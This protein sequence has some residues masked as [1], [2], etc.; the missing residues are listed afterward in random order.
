MDSYNLEIKKIDSEFVLVNYDK[1][2]F[3]AQGKIEVK[4]KSKSF[5]EY[6]LKDFER[7][8]EISVKEDNTIDFN[9]KFCAYAIYSDQKYLI[10]DVNNKNYQDDLSNLQLKYDL[11]LITTSNGPPFETQQLGLLSAVRN[12]IIEIVGKENFLKMSSYAWGAYYDKMSE[13][14]DHGVGEPISDEEYKKSKIKEKLT[15]IFQR[16]F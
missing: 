11:S 6:L 5:L 7:C 3:I 10:E 8:A 1:P 4:S 16:F 13:G 2:V 12:K 14:L 15:N 9:G